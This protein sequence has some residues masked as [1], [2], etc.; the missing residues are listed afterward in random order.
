MC[1]NA[2]STTTTPFPPQVTVTVDNS[3]PCA[4]PCDHIRLEFVCVPPAFRVDS[5]RSRTASE[6]RARPTST[7][8]GTLEAFTAGSTYV[9]PP[10]ECVCVCVCVCVWVGAGAACPLQLLQFLLI[11]L[12]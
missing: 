11:R 12:L 5:Y 10:T 4:F 9:P 2:P 7:T 6:D 8:V 3:L 1:P